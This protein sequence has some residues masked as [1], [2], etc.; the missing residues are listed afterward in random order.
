M[1]ENK[2]PGAQPKIIDFGLSKKFS[3]APKYMGERVG[4]IYTMSPEVLAGI[5]N[6]KVDLWS[7]GVI[8]Y[9]LLCTSKPFYDRNRRK[10]VERIT[11]GEYKR[12]GP[13]WESLSPE[14]RDFVQKLLV[15]DPKHR[16]DAA[17]ALK[18]PW[19]VSRE[20]LPNEKPAPDVLASIDGALTSYVHTSALKK[21][22][23]MVIAHKSTAPA[24]EAL[25]AV[26]EEFD[27]SRDGV[28]SFDELK[29]AF[30]RC[31]FCDEEI[32]KVFTS[33]VRFRRFFGAL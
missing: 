11:K 19:L 22:G 3:G 7:I 33:L 4:T 14:A 23:L 26:F 31:N 20:Q 15:V 6:S 28:L 25:R 13:A 10:M 27:T 1:F 21:L 17:Q 9:M 2:G 24:I 5:Y 12:D 30:V 32:Q 8:T 16:L 18:H 29:A